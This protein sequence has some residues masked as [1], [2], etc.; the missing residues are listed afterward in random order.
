MERGYAMRGSLRGLLILPL[1]AIVLAGCSSGSSGGQTSGSGDS[2]STTSKTALPHITI[3]Y[4]DIAATVAEEPQI[5]KVFQQ[6]AAD[7]GWTV[8]LADAQNSPTTALQ[9][10]QAFINE[11]VNAL[12]FCSVPGAFVGSALQLAK[13]RHIPTINIVSASAGAAY[14]SQVAGTETVASLNPLITAMKS[15]LHP[16]AAVGLLILAQVLEGTPEAIALEKAITGAGF[17]V[18]QT[19]YPSISDAPQSTEDSVSAIVRAHP[20]VAAIVDLAGLVSSD[21]LGLRDAHNTTTK[22]YGWNVDNATVP[23]LLTPHSQLAALFYADHGK[24]AAVALDELVQYFGRKTPLEPLIN[25]TG[26]V[27]YTASNLPAFIKADP[28]GNAS[29]VTPAQVLA[30]Y[31]A[32]WAKEF[33]AK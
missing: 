5:F 16:G 1:V 6:G 25:V 8:K 4:V 32:A 9:D 18:V 20:N 10:T 15:E 30:P 14:D 24:P 12:V 3:G 21:V 31:V 33:K 27:I 17:N 23:T 7:L 19:D 2:A 29:P 28:D 11:G 22:I 13:Q 26:G